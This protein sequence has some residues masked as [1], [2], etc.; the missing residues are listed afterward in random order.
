MYM[1]TGTCVCVCVCVCVCA[2]VHDQS[3]DSFEE[4][5]SRQASLYMYTRTAHA[6]SSICLPIGSSP[7]I[8]RSDITLTV[9]WDGLFSSPYPLYYEVSLGTQVGSGSIER[10][11]PVETDV[12]QIVI[13]NTNLNLLQEYFLSLTAIGFNG[14]SHTANYMVIETMAIPIN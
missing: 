4:S 8:T 14:L 9:T 13:T 1:C 2:C 11:N 5:R 7:I 12:T 3:G 10:W 6:T